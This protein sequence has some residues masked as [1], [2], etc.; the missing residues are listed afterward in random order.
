MSSEYFMSL[1][2]IVSKKLKGELIV[3]LTQQKQHIV[4]RFLLALNFSKLTNKAIA[5]LTCKSMIMIVILGLHSHSFR[6]L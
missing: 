2:E 3:I 5:N 6:S 1:M 4:A